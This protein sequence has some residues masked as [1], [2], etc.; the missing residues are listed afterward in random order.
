MSFQIH[1]VLGQS[2]LKKGALIDGISDFKEL[3]KVF[4]TK[5]NVLVLFISN[6]RESQNVIRALDEA[7]EQVKGEATTILVDCSIR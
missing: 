4:R 1:L 2:K 3:K 7:A 5:N 6:T